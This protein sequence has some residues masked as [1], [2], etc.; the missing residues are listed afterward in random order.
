MS[1]WNKAGES[2][3]YCGTQVM[4]IK[5]FTKLFIVLFEGKNQAGQSWYGQDI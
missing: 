2:L 4:E 3:Q 5:A 1:L